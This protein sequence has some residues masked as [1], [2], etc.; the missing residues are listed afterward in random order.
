MPRVRRGEARRG[1]VVYG[2][3]SLL[4]CLAV[5]VMVVVKRLVVTPLSGS[6]LTLIPSPPPPLLP[7]ATSTPTMQGFQFIKQRFTCHLSDHSLFSSS[8]NGELVKDCRKYPTDLFILVSYPGT[9]FFFHYYYLTTF[10]A[11]A[12]HLYVSLLPLHLC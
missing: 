7:P 10:S 8:F 2:C 3:G 1:R 5:E 6:T 12:H 9:Y 4:L 11:T